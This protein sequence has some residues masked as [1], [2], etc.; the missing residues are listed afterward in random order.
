ME[1][2]RCFLAQLTH[3]RTVFPLASLFFL[4][5]ILGILG[6]S[7][8]LSIIV[9]VLGFVILSI[10]LHLLLNLHRRARAVNGP[11]L[12]VRVDGVPSDKKISDQQYA[13]IILGA[14]YDPWLYIRQLLNIISVT[15]KGLQL[16]FSGIPIIVFW[17]WS[18]F[19]FFE[20]QCFPRNDHVNAEQSAGQ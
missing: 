20:S 3:Q 18:S 5:L 13:S 15:Y 4:N 12:H 2:I 6:V 10:P 9:S 7:P 14:V 11:M 17:G 8:V 19:L 1:A 16:A